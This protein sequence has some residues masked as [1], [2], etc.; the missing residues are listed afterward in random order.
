MEEYENGCGKGDPL[1]AGRLAKE[2][3]KCGGRV[4]SLLEWTKI[5]QSNGPFSK[6]S[7]SGCV[8]YPHMKL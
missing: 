5:A 7:L 3:W 2:D 4:A 8:R 6:E 1:L